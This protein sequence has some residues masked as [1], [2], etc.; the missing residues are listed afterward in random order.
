MGLVPRSS[1][2]FRWFTVG[3][4]SARHAL[5]APVPKPQRQLTYA[6]MRAVPLGG[7]GCTLESEPPPESAQLAQPASPVCMPPPSEVD[8][9][10]SEV[11]PSRVPPPEASAPSS[12]GHPVHVEPPLPGESEED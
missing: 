8:D 1:H 3:S 12:P 2:V 7:G 6:T 5:F 4:G 11:E 10:P 9:G